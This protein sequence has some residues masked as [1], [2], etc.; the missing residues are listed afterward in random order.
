MATA[1]ASLISATPCPTDNPNDSD[2][3]DVCESV[4]NCPAV[5]NSFQE[6]TDGDGQGNACDA[7]SHDV[8][9]DM[10]EDG[11]CGNVDNCPTIANAHQEDADNDGLGDACDSCPDDALNDYDGDS[12]CG[13]IDNCPFVANALQEDNDA[14]GIGNAC[15]ICANDADND[16]DGDGHCANFD[17]C[18]TLAN[19]LQ[20]DLD[21]D[22]LGD[23]CDDCPNDPD[24]DSDSDD[25]CGDI[26]NCPTLAN[27]LQ[28]DADSDGQGDACDACPNDADNDADADG[29]CGD[30]DNCPAFANAL[31]EDA[32]SDGLGDSCDAFPLGSA[33]PIEGSVVMWMG[34]LEQDSD[35]FWHPLVNGVADLNWY[36]CDGS[37]LGSITLP[38]L[39]DRYIVGAESSDQIGQSGGH[40]SLA[41]TT[42]T[43][44]EHRHWI[45]T[46][47]GDAGHHSHTI[48]DRTNNIWQIWV[49]A[50][51]GIYTGAEMKESWRTTS[52]DGAHQHNGPSN[53]LV[54]GQSSPTPMVLDPSH[55]VV[56]YLMAIPSHPIDEASVQLLPLDSML[57]WRG[58]LAELDGIYHPTSG[59]SANTEW[60]FCDGNANTLDLRGRYIKGATDLSRHGLMGGANT[61]VLTQDQLPPHS[62]DLPDLEE[63]EWVHEHSFSD[64]FSAA[65]SIG[66]AIIGD[67][68]G[69]NWGHYQEGL[70][71]S[72]ST[73]NSGYHRH[74][75]IGQTYDRG[76]SA[77][78]D[79]R[80]PYTQLAALNYQGANSV[81]PVGSI[82][83]WSGDFD[84]SGHPIVA[85]SALPN[86]HLC[87]GSEAGIPDLRGFMLK[88]Q[89]E[90]SS[91][92]DSGGANSLS[93]SLEHL[94]QHQ[95]SANVYVDWGGTHHHTLYDRRIDPG[96][97]DAS[98]VLGVNLDL[99]GFTHRTTTT[100][101][102]SESHS[103]SGGKT[104]T[105]GQ[106]APIDI[107]PAYTELSFIICTANST[108]TP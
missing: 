28:E 65:V 23:A 19:V 57:W 73:F 107:Q 78:I 48:P 102:F 76:A 68:N 92:G 103:H 41:L 43:M 69:Q 71:E 40:A 72:H 5:S 62:H 66:T 99:E 75:I 67:A 63:T 42:S 35:G 45:D 22:G 58:Q 88:G 108:E 4:D 7:C 10:D 17:N 106:G 26:D 93:L 50:G 56:H 95:H 25:L 2:G 8:D 79:I 3:D 101:P 1:M 84:A 21:A 51:T 100:E 90:G 85:G 6:D 96:Y 39:R 32:D 31:Q 11:R 55:K 9:N 60:R 36:L 74:D 34:E 86:W 24:N 12:Q 20:E 83:L 37:T 53:T 44:P 87:D 70:V 38:D 80:P 64:S 105:T 13:D 89:G 14:D 46:Q 52:D 33:P 77:T 15:D 97:S 30:V 47:S 104:D 29:I 94:P 18:P 54:E 16:S 81:A 49:V 91:V 82:V 27:S 59:G 98:W 61:R